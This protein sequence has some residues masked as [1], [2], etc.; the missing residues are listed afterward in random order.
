MMWHTE[1]QINKVLLG[2]TQDTSENLFYS[3]SYYA[4]ISL[5]KCK[6]IGSC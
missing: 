1:T 3:K 6:S 4:T 5:N 2:N